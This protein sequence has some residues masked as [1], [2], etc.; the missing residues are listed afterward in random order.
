M[1]SNSKLTRISSIEGKNEPVKKVEYQSLIGSLI[2]LSVS[3]RPDIAYAVSA[4]GQFSNDPR[5]Q[6]WNAAKRFLRYLKGTSCLKM[7]YMKSNEALHG[8]V[9]AEWGGN[10]ID[11]KSHSGIESCEGLAAQRAHHRLLTLAN[12]KSEIG[13]RVRRNQTTV[14]RICDRR[15]KEG[16]TNRRVRS[17]PPQYTTSRADRHIVSMAVADRSVTSVCNASSSVCV[18]HSTPFTA[19]WS[20]RRP[21]LRLPLTQNNR[22]HHR[23]WCDERRMWTAKW[24]EIV[25]TDKSRFCFQHHDGRIESGYTVG[26]GC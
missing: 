4:L 2:Y 5:R 21:L 3:T 1:D 11:R 17:H 7:A 9:D 14:M 22:R 26:R 13:S 6:Q 23:Q 12:F 19:E 18:Y 10:L 25:F 20:A 24:D 16:T 15:M 8:Y